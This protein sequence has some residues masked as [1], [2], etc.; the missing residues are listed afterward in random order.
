MSSGCPKLR[1]RRS[2]LERPPLL[3]SLPSY[4]LVVFSPSVLAYS[5][6]L[7]PHTATTTQPTYGGKQGR[8]V[9]VGGIPPTVSLE[10]FRGYFIKFGAIEEA[11][12][13]EDPKTGR[14]RGFGFVLY[15]DDEAARKACES[16]YHSI[17]IYVS[18]F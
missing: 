1:P 12:I 6:P 7:P 17:D 4:A 8:K 2:P 10:M 18:P 15:Q 9:F 5:P 16:Q 14:P 3:M 13:M 11:I